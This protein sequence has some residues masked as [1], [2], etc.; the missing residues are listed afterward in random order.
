MGFLNLIIT[1]VLLLATGYHLQDHRQLKSE[2]AEIKEAVGFIRKDINTELKII[3]KDIQ[4]YAKSVQATE[5]LPQALTLKEKLQGYAA[6]VKE[7]GTITRLKDKP[8]Y[9]YTHSGEKVQYDCLL[10]NPT[11]KQLTTDDEE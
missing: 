7:S 3:S 4:L 6:P 10:G 8:C 9:Y 1:A 2:L 11:K 5:A